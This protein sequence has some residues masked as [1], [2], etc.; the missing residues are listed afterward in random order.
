MD[1]LT[2]CR[3]LD[4]EPD[5]SREE[6]KE[7][8]AGMVKRYHPEDYPMEFAQVQ[9]AYRLLMKGKRRKRAR[10]QENAEDGVFDWSETTGKD[11]TA[12]HRNAAEHKN[13]TEG[14]HAAQSRNTAEHEDIAEKE[15]FFERRFQEVDQREEL[16]QQEDQARW[17]EEIARREAR[18]LE[19]KREEEEAQRREQEA[20]RWAAQYL[21]NILRDPSMS[22]KPEVYSRYFLNPQVQEVMDCRG[23]IRQL[24]KLLEKYPQKPKIYRLIRNIYQH[25]PEGVL[26]PKL[27]LF[28]NEKMGADTDEMRSF[29]IFWFIII[30]VEIYN[31]IRSIWDGGLLA[32]IITF[33][34]F[35]VILVGYRRMRRSYSY[36]ISQIC[37]S[38]TLLA[39][40][41]VCVLAEIF[42]L[43]RNPGGTTLMLELWILCAGWLIILGIWS[44]VASIIDW[45]KRKKS[46]Y[47]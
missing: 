23:Y 40:L 15:K 29:P 16:R 32:L 13:V 34:V 37:V 43:W 41:T 22:R 27:M 42:C 31:L 7:A 44:A 18:A 14:G 2:A 35:D 28:L 20:V 4:I 25:R 10:Q 11:N 19:K 45:R 1:Q 8:Y 30:V 3:I 36:R 5:S 33:F 46:K 38:L 12:E 6:I 47:T 21:E 39:V 9:E 24:L 17:E 26:T